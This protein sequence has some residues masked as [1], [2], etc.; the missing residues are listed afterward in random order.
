MAKEKGEKKKGR[1]FLWIIIGVFVVIIVIAIG[2]QSGTGSTSTSSP[3]PT[4]TQTEYNEKSVALDYRAAM[5]GDIEEGTLIVITGGIIQ[6]YQ[7]K[8]ALF[9]TEKNEFSESGYAGDSVWLAFKEKP[10]LIENDT[11]KI[12]GRYQGT[13]KY[14]TVLKTEKEVPLIQ[15]DYYEVVQ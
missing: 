1:R 15:V 2:S 6:M 3:T 10:K 13:G 14:K 9:G 11:V 7:D 12:F 8:S 4:P 5:F